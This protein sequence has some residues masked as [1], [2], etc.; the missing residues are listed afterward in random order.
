MDRIVDHADLRLAVAHE[1]DRDAEVRNAARKIGC[2][3]DRID[4]PDLASE[5][6]AGFLAEERILRETLH[7]TAPDELLHPAV[8][9]G[10][11][12]LWSLENQRFALRAVAIGA[13]RKRP[14]FACDLA[15]AIEPL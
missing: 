14:G 7:E 4:N 5:N 12:I 2:A 10:Q 13:E 11:V 15:R 6:A 3:V 8:G 1:A 9:V